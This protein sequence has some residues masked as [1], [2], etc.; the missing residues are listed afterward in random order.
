MKR[1]T[2]LSIN[3]FPCSARKVLLGRTAARRSRPARARN[4][5]PCTGAT[6]WA[7]CKALFQVPEALAVL[8]MLV[9]PLYIYATA[10]LAAVLFFLLPSLLLPPTP[11]LS[12]FINDARLKA[13]T[14]PSPNPTTI[15]AEITKRRRLTAARLGT[16]GKMGGARLGRRCK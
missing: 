2:A 7:D 16:R 15:R 13:A 10:T 9:G 11:P 8:F 4:A 14:L 12:L 5:P 6:I 3:P 1:D